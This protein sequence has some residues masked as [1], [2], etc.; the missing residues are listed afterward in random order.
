MLL[1]VRALK[2]DELHHR[3]AGA[4]AADAR[5][6]P[7][8]GRLGDLLLSGHGS[9]SLAGID[10]VISRRAPERQRVMAESVQR[11]KSGEGASLS[12][13]SSS[14]KFSSRR[15]CPAWRATADAT[16]CGDNHREECM[17]EVSSGTWIAR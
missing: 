1:A 17:G 5:P 10:L 14:T 11:R 7:G 16:S 8:L 15:Q 2:F 3:G 13:K 6:S 9:G 4:G 12:L